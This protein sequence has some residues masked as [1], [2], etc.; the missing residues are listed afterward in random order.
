MAVGLDLKK[1]SSMLKKT[2]VVLSFVVDVPLA[3][4][5]S[6]DPNYMRHGIHKT[7]AHHTHNKTQRHIELFI[8]VGLRTHTELKTPC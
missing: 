4:V 2:V 8:H 1:A 3:H 7:C 5:L 6:Q